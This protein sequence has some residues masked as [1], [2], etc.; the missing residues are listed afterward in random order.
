MTTTGAPEQMNYDT[1]SLAVADG[2]ATLT[3]N[4][5]DALNALSMRML[6]ELRSALKEVAGAP[7]VRCL[8]LTGAG[9]GFCSGVDLTDQRTGLNPGDRDEFMRDYFM[10]PY[11]LLASL[12]IPTIAAVNGVAAGAGMSLALTC[13][14]VIAAES[15]YF[16]QPFTNIGLVPDLGSSWFLPHMVGKARAAGL[17]LLGERLSAKS[18]AEWG[19]IWKCVEDGQL[20]AEIGSVTGK[21][22]GGARLS[23]ALIKQLLRQAFQNDLGV[24]MQR[25]GEYQS[26]CLRSDDFAE[27]RLAFAEKRKPA[28][29]AT[30]A[31]RSA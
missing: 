30:H 29:G 24:Q 13:D 5:P 25:E 14:I 19:L 22:A 11:Q 18:A 12:A 20:P 28:F 27:A 1:L 21:F 3:L 15:S 26:V 10:P 31:S 9:R 2:I 7:D 16:L 23:H 17:M 4:R 6:I 8:V